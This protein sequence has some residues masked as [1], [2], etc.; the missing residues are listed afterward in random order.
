MTGD[1]EADAGGDRM[2]GWCL[3]VLVAVLQSLELETEFLK[4]CN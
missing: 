2:K 4:N 1:S 3:S